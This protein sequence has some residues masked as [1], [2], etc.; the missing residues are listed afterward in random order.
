MA[1][2]RKLCKARCDAAGEAEPG[3]WSGN[4]DVL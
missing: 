3:V 4:E 2:A 1:A